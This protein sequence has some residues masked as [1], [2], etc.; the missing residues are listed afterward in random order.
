VDDDPR[1][2]FSSVLTVGHSKR[3]LLG[4][5][6]RAAKLK[7]GLRVL[8]AITDRRQPDPFDVQELFAYAPQFRGMPLN[9]LAGAVIRDA[10]KTLK[11]EYRR[12]A[13]P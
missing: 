3:A 6:C 2:I 5:S 12:A 11:A 13:S 1:L 8:T 4:N 10:I 9:E 7:T